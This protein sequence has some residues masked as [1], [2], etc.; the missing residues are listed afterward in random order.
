MYAHANRQKIQ[1]QN[2]IEKKDLMLIVDLFTAKQHVMGMVFFS[3]LNTLCLLR[4]AYTHCIFFF[5]YAGVSSTLNVHFYL[6]EL[7]KVAKC[8]AFYSNFIYF[9]F[10]F[11]KITTRRNGFDLFKDKNYLL[12]FRSTFFAIALFCFV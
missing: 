1:K 7:M 9:F 11:K 12:C 4:T 2:K 5:F 6:L 3:L 10:V 8:L